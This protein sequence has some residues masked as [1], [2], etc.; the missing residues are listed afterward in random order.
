MCRHSVQTRTL[1]QRGSMGMRGI[2]VAAASVA[3]VMFSGVS[4]AVA[5]D[6][7]TMP[8]K[9]PVLKAVGPTTCTN[10]ADFFTTACQLSWYGVRFYGTI[11]VG[12]G[13]QTNG[14]PFNKDY[15][16]GTNY[17]ISKP[18]QGGKWLLSPNALSTSNVGVEVK[19]P[20]VAG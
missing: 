1:S 14:S 7:D 9:A 18:N 4:G 6:L 17:L 19:E 3:V 13:Y 5:A 10:I 12:Y 20:L 16:W 8:V 11:D 15:T 2:D